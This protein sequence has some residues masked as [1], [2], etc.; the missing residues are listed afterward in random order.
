MGGDGV[1]DYVYECTSMYG[2]W[3][4]VLLPSLKKLSLI[5]A[6]SF[7]ALMQSLNL[8]LQH[9]IVGT[10]SSHTFYLTMTVRVR[11]IQPPS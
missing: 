9:V 4:G 6:P 2:V 11:Y 10:R 1:K 5:A 7:P 8:V 3:G